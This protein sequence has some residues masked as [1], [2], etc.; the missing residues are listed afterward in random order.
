MR[1]ACE[2]CAAPLRADGVAYV[3]TYECTFCA[4]CAAAMNAV[5]PNCHGELVRRPRH[6]DVRTAARTLAPPDA[7]VADGVGVIPRDL[8]ERVQ[9]YADIRSVAFVAWHPTRRE[10]FAHAR[11]G[12]TAQI[13]RVAAPHGALAQLTFAD[14]P[15]TIAAAPRALADRAI[16]F[17]RDRAG[18][19]FF[20]I[21]SLDLATGAVTQLT[22]GERTQNEIGPCAH[23]APWFAYSSTSRTGVDRDVWI[24]D[25]RDPSGARCVMQGD[26]GGWFVLDVSHDDARLLVRE[27]VSVSESWLWLVDIAS[28][29]RR[30]VTARGGARDAYGDARCLPDGSRLLATTTAGS[31]FQRLAL[32]DAASGAM[33]PL[34]AHVAADVDAFAVSHDSARVAYATNEAG[35]SVLR[36]RDL[37]SGDEH[38]VSDLPQGVITT[39]AWRAHSSECAFTLS[40][41]EEPPDAYSYDAGARTVTRWTHSDI[42]GHPRPT[43]ARAELIRWRSF[44]DREIT[45]FLYRPPGASAAPA[46]RLPVLIWI[47]GGP[48]SQMR[49]EFR[50][51]ANAYTNELGV[52]TIY[53][54]VRGSTGFGRTFVTLDDGVRRED[55]VRDIGALLDWIAAQ[56]DLDA[57]RVM[58]AGRSY[59]GYMVLA[60]AVHYGAR[61]RCFAE[62]VGISNF[63]TFLENTEAYR[64]DLRRVEYGDER[65]PQ[66][67]AFL[68]EMSPLT[69][70][71]RMTRP[72]LIAQGR[73]DPRVPVTESEQMVRA[74]RA[75]GVPV[76]YL[77]AAD[78]GHVFQKKPNEEYFA[79]ALVA[80]AREYLLGGSGR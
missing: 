59:G 8:A 10:M 50:G 72:L 39:L 36:V 37:A 62:A 79:C 4:S 69:H 27:Y 65:D 26:G 67:R 22:N 55:S 21:F 71:D 52:V 54:N 46:A 20:H 78:E 63:V 49:P 43:F 33:T 77:L 31:E 68:Q 15:V 42:G 75:R 9:R 2:R 41:A 23:R 57:E 61:V 24:M 5:C 56:D 40:H 11:T 30:C 47:H 6:G 60:C 66:M 25:P 32:L 13:H 12:R 29:E 74:L 76:W 34:S 16:L 80:F 3:C 1:T 17:Q 48:E 70:V 14:E 7:M 18:D 28:G 19:E 35:V 38:V 51:A 64:R 53:P 73:N 45:G 58:I 44:D